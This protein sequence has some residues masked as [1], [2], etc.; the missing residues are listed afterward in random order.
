MGTTTGTLSSAPEVTISAEGESVLFTRATDG[1]G[2]TSDWRAQSVRIDSLVPTVA[3][4]CG[5]GAWSGVAVSCAVPC[6]RS[7][8]SPGGRPRARID[9]GRVDAPLVALAR[10]G[11]WRVER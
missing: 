9:R 6:L 11:V 10:G 4:D 2:H 8:A 7:R 3:L 1:A 5:D